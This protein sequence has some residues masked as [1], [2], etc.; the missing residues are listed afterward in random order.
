MPIKK[1]KTF[2]LGIDGASFEV[3]S[4]LM[5]RGMLPNMQQVTENGV[6]GVLNSTIPSLSAPAW[7]SFMTGKNPGHY[8]TYHFRRININSYE[9]KANHQL[10]NSSYFRGDTFF[11]YLGHLGY[12]VGVVTVPVTYPPWKVNGFLISG[13]PCPD[14]AQNPNFT[15]PSEIADLLPHNLNWTEIE[16]ARTIPK[17]EMRGARD[18]DDVLKGGIVM[19]NRRTACTLDLM[20]RFHCDLTILVWGAIDRAQHML[21]KYHDAGHFLHEKGNRFQNYL[22]QLYCNA[23]R[24]LGQI[25]KS[26]GPDT[27]LFIVSDHGAGPKQ[28][29]HFHLNAWLQQNGYLKTTIKA[30]WLDNPFSQWLKKPLRNIVLRWN[31][32]HWNSMV[33]TKQSFSR[34]NL[35][36]KKTLAYR[37]PIDEQAEG[38][39]INLKGRQ[40]SGIVD[41]SNYES[42]RTKLMDKLC[43]TYDPRSGKPI[44]K[45]C[46]KREELYSGSRQGEAP[47]II[48]VFEENYFPGSGCNGPLFSS[49]PPIYLEALSGNHRQEGIF[50]ACG[51]HIATGKLQ[52]GASIM[53][54]AP[55][56]LYGIGEN[57]PKEMEGNV[58]KSVFQPDRLKK[59][60]IYVN[61]ELIGIS[62]IADLTAQEQKSMEDQLKDLGYL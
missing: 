20:A 58:L 43:K 57:V 8:G 21:W 12:R 24:L 52:K 59:A 44:I 48:I 13:Y 37:F 39:V 30:K 46:F 17:E 45:Q 22:E 2:I 31:V 41:K 55:T 15:F 11:D 14:P 23:D 10:I 36:Y 53:D 35:N 47:D 29:S 56:V 9:N 51:P 62:G 61:S 5:A 49:I 27:Q 50:M 19:M 33:K 28:G 6:C 60:P 16:N 26:I 34:H 25:M 4:P 42:L 18:P 32:R 1:Q 54:V 40:P 7:V 38:L 3:I